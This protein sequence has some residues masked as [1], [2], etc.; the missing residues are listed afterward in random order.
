MHFCPVRVLLGSENPTNLGTG[1][2]WCGFYTRRKLLITNRYHDVGSAVRALLEELDGIT[3]NP[4]Q[5]CAHSLK[6][7]LGRCLIKRSGH[8]DTGQGSQRPVNPILS[9]EAIGSGCHFDQLSLYKVDLLRGQSCMRS[10]LTP[11]LFE[12]SNK[13][14]SLSSRER[15]ILCVLV[16]VSRRQPWARRDLGQQDFRERVTGVEQANLEHTNRRFKE[17][18]PPDTQGHFRVRHSGSSDDNPSTVLDDVQHGDNDTAQ[19]AYVAVAVS[20]LNCL[21]IQDCLALKLATRVVQRNN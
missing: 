5:R 17:G 18:R 4:T 13:P 1:G 10:D 6:K 14:L 11:D 3:D 16:D 9:T 12:A 2:A 21:L 15:R 8:C 20:D 19:F 7:H